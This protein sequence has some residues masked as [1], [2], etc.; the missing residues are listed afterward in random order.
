MV[1]RNKFS[2]KLEENSFLFSP[3]ENVTSSSAAISLIATFSMPLVSAATTVPVPFTLSSVYLL[4]RKSSYN[5]GKSTSLQSRRTA[6]TSGFSTNK[7][8][9]TA[10]TSNV[11]GHGVTR[12][13][14]SSHLSALMTTS[15]LHTGDTMESAPVFTTTWATVCV[16]SASKSFPVSR[17]SLHLLPSRLT[18]SSQLKELQRTETTRVTISLEFHYTSKSVSQTSLFPQMSRSNRGA[19][20]SK[21]T[22]PST[23]LHRTLGLK[24]SASLS[25][26]SSPPSVPSPQIGAPTDQP[27]ET[28]KM[29][30]SSLR[31]YITLGRQNRTLLP[32]LS[33]PL[34]VSSSQ[35]DVPT[36]TSTSTIGLPCT[37]HEEI[38]TKSTET[39]EEMIS[40]T[41]QRQTF[42]SVSNP[43]TVASTLMSSSSVGLRCATN[44]EVTVLPTA[45]PEEMSAMPG[46]MV[47][48]QPVKGD[49]ELVRTQRATSLHTF[50]QYQ[51]RIIIL[52]ID[53]ENSL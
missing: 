13:K 53:G 31:L 21:M 19:E 28:A 39:K 12:T 50:L 8:D 45:Q 51:T 24:N 14:I 25:Q 35:P 42:P 49:Q 3:T 30:F 40:L 23:R 5:V 47:Q 32:Q 16:S 7:A 20:I 46:I 9:N 27:T 26:L 33:S 15:T 6:N 1:I 11:P 17:N 4:Q 43:Q 36:L 37:T 34:S 44:E 10:L 2:L 22:N 29:A 41:I 38:I 52:N 48:F 18:T